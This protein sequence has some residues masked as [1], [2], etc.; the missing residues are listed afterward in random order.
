MIHKVLVITFKQDLRDNGKIIYF[1]QLLLF[2]LKKKK[3]LNGELLIKEIN[4]KK[5]DEGGNV[6]N[7]TKRFTEMI[8]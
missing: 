1:F 2:I 8:I 6:A 7:I 4:K 5:V 3:N